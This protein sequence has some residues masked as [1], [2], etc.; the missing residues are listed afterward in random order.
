M[1]QRLCRFRC[2]N[3]YQFVID[4]RHRSESVWDVAH[5]NLRN[6]SR[7]QNIHSDRNARHRKIEVGDK[8]L[9]LLPKKTNKLLL[10]WKGPYSVLENFNGYD[11]RIQ[12]RSKLKTFHANLLRKYIE[13]ET[14]E[15]NVDGHVSVA[16]L[17][18]DVKDSDQNCRKEED[19]L[20]V[21]PSMQSLETSDDVCISD[22]LTAEQKSEVSDL[23]RQ[24]FG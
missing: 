8:V 7:K 24:F 16:V 13:R 18:I 6:A 2:E 3:A 10:Q 20:I 5:A 11:Y 21:N 22:N 19:D 23:V 9:V 1:V 12:V 4:L 15:E 17:D 14:V